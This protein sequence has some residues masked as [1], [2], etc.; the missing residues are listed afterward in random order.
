[1]RFLLG[2]IVFVSIMISMGCQSFA[3]KEVVTKI[4]FG[5]VE[6]VKSYL[7]TGG[8]VDVKTQHGWSLLQHAIIQG[9]PKL[10]ELLLNARGNP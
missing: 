9:K 2:L 10:V 3:T 4:N 5:N 8:D 7:A 1:M 6:G